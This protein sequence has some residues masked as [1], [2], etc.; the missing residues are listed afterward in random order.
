M[1]G[2]GPR[3]CR[4]GAL[5]SKTYGALCTLEILETSEEETLMTVLA[6]PPEDVRRELE[7]LVARIR[8]RGVGE[9]VPRPSEEATK[10]FVA[11]LR[12]EE[13]M[14]ETELQAHERLWRTVEER[15]A[16]D[17]A[18]ERADRRS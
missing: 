6:I 4:S 3:S 7:Q 1:L 2:G 9:V 11:R 10:G 17:E 14:S 12:G 5:F 15:R 8:A 16:S 13:P 18:D